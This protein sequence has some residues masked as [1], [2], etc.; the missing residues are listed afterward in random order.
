M[1]PRWLQGVQLL[2]GPGAAL[3]PLDALIGADGVLEDLGA[4]AAQRGGALGLQPIPASGWILAPVLVDPHSVLEDPWD[5]RSETL[6]TLAAA[7]ASGGYG[8]VALLP[9]ARPWRDRPERLTLRWPDPQRLLLWGSFSRDGA[10]ADLGP[11]ADQ[12]EAGAIGLACGA[13]CPPLSL[14]E[15]GLLLAESAP[16]PVLVAPRQ[17]ALTSG[18]FVRE[19]VEALRAGWPPD[20]LASELL[21]LA[22]LLILA[23]RPGGQSLMLMNLSTAAGVDALARAPRRPSVTVG[24]W[25]LV[26]DSA[27]LAPTDEGWRVEPSLGTPA[28]REALLSALRQGLIQA[29]AVH[30]QPVDAE[31]RLLPLDQRRPG[32]AG[33]GGRH[34]LVLPA[35]WQ[36]LVERRHW[37]AAELWQVLSWG[38]SALLRQPPE[39][40]AAGSRRWLLFDPKARSGTAPGPS[41]SRAANQPLQGR[42][43]LGVV[44][45]SG[46]TE[47]AQWWLD[48]PEAEEA[49]FPPA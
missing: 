1:A 31:E 27:S 16:R 13:E 25:H 26:A 33:H 11:H 40:I 46:L 6:A 17:S 7:A 48:P 37:T 5:G 43:P 28:D 8:T 12:L 49:G 32:V 42:P 22:A 24:W 44:R 3:E 35:L 2:R 45:A 19:G 15:R 36:E 47:A 4:Q 10:D 21:P 41:P 39:Q 9:W 34:G 29:V 38:P 18:G 30:H 14:L 20:P 23:D